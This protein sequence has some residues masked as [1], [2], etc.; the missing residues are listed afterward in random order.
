MTLL[1]NIFGV[2]VSNV[3]NFGTS[4]L[5]NFILPM[6]LT[7]ADYG[8][9]KQ[10]ILYM[11]FTY[12]F[13]LGFNDGIYIKYGGVDDE[14]LDEA[15]VKDEHNFILSF[16][17]VIFVIMLAYAIWQQSIIFTFFTIATFFNAMMTYHQN[18]LQATGKFKFYSSSSILKSIFNIIAL[19]V[20]IFLLQSTNYVTYIAIHAISIVFLF[21][22]YEY[23]F[24][25]RF[26]FS[27]RFNSA[28]K[29]DIFKVGFFILIANMS[30]TFVGNLGSWVVQ[31]EYN[32]ESFAQYSFQNSVLNVILL[33]VNAVGLVFYNVISK[34]NDLKVLNAI[35][36]VS[37]Y[38]GIGSGLAF[39]IFKV[40]IELFLPQ[41]VAAISLLSITFI[42]IPYIMLS[43]I[44]I[45]NL[46]KTSV[47]ENIYF[48]DSL[49]FAV[50]SLLFVY[51]FQLIFGNME[52]IAMGTT[53][54]YLLWFLYASWIKFPYLK[55]SLREILLLVSHFVVFL[56]FANYLTPTVGF[57]AYAIYLFIIYFIDR[58]EIQDIIQLFK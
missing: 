2:A 50:L 44:L 48:R 17:F 20:A 16:Q 28:G 14:A 47:S 40:I 42:A 54:S 12:L 33:I 36:I 6:I 30:L 29:F 18:F 49:C 56:L 57:I 51:A 22:I 34:R 46:Y 24:A 53:L 26:G 5:I 43:N 37:I 27:F 38:L 3:V 41:Y 52:A 58:Q 32:I 13:N 21:I 45:S 8:N 19:L 25:K 11:S 15:T 1:K 55:S 35:K 4:F 31:W 10:Y 23:Y 39:F 9:Y 7:V